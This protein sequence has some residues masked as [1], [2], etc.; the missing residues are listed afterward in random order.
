M[1]FTDSDI[2]TL[3]PQLV[4]LF[5]EVQKKP[6]GGLAGESVSLVGVGKCSKL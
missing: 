6:A 5:G 3:G 2:W 1:T 4:V